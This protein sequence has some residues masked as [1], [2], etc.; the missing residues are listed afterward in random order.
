[1]AEPD[2]RHPR[3]EAL[4]ALLLACATV[5]VVGQTA[6]QGIAYALTDAPSHLTRASAQTLNV[7]SNDLVITTAVGAFMFGLV[8]GL[9]ILR[10]V[11]LPR[12][13]GWLSIVLG[14]LWVTPLEG[15]GFFGLLVWVI[16][17]SVLVFRQASAEPAELLPT[18]G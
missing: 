11:G 13:L 2:G 14:V 5:H 3:A 10:G 6:G 1:V 4:S 8:A 12:S 9:T 15:I 18:A 16:A 7:L 17:V